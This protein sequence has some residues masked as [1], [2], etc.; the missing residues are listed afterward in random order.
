MP[1][2]SEFQMKPMVWATGEVGF[3][4]I[5]TGAAPAG[6][7]KV[8]WEYAREGS[9]HPRNPPLRDSLK[10]DF[11]PRE[12]FEQRFEPGNHD[13]DLYLLVDAGDGPATR[14]WMMDPSVLERTD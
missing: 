11:L 1:S 8:Q 5:Y 6:Q 14:E 4:V 3:Q 13:D 10:M 12:V 7:V 2:T 9:Q